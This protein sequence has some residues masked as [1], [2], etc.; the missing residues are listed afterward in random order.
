MN[1]RDA[2]RR[3]L[4]RDH[5]AG[6]NLQGLLQCLGSR[7][8]EYG[9]REFLPVID[10]DP[11]HITGT[12]PYTL[13]YAWPFPQVFLG[14]D[15][16]LIADQAALYTIGYGGAPA[17]VTLYDAAHF[18]EA[19]VPTADIVGGGGAWHFMDMYSAWMLINEKNIIFKVGW[20]SRVFIVNNDNQGNCC[21][22]FNAGWGWTGSPTWAIYST[23]K[24]KLDTASGPTV[25]PHAVATLPFV[26][27][28][29]SVAPAK[30]YAVSYVVSSTDFTGPVYITV[31]IGGVS[32][33]E[34]TISAPETYTETIWS[35][36]VASPTVVITGRA[37][38][39]KSIVLNSISVTIADAPVISTG[40]VHKEGRPIFAGFSNAYNWANWPALLNDFTYFPAEH[41]I[42]TLIGVTAPASNWV[43]WGSV[44]APDLL[45]LLSLYLLKYQSLRCIEAT[46]TTGFYDSINTGNST[47]RNW[48]L[49]H[50]INMRQFGMRPMPYKGAVVKTLPIGDAVLCFGMNSQVSQGGVSALI[51][52]RAAGDITYSTRHLIN[53]GI[54]SRAAAAGDDLDAVFVDEESQLWTIDNKLGFERLGYQHDLDDISQSTMVVSFDQRNRE[55]YICGTTTGGDY[56]GFMLN[57]NGFSRMPIA[58]TGVAGIGPDLYGPVWPSGNLI[59]TAKIWQTD[60]FAPP[61]TEDFPQ[62]ARVKLVGPIQDWT[63]YTV[64]IEYDF[65]DGVWQTATINSVSAFPVDARGHV[66]K[67]ISG[68]R[69]RLTINHAGATTAYLDD[70]IVEFSNGDKRMLGYRL[71]DAA[72]H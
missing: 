54:I 49:D 53:V 23:T 34:R 10:V 46:P 14:K 30:Q 37:A 50:L 42:R 4:R 52:T 3:G 65:G 31:T 8:T 62:I 48:F 24:L 39:D 55:F 60:E 44:N 36:D 63:K 71:N 45:W 27:E 32:S 12:T 57:K 72:T 69:F 13:S 51:D 58:T 29:I 47:Y 9:S 25:A 56:R 28:T 7:C 41:P 11:N 6:P 16:I 67:M 70:I 22:A 26:S 5:R 35:G 43:W 15:L 1:F 40:C 21:P 20:D 59:S 19:T 17:I 68:A 2:I 18:G 33:T 38:K 61:T 64:T 66:D